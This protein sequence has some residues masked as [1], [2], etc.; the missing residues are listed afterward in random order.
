MGMVS[1]IKDR[2]R[3]ADSAV[4]RKGR[5][6]TIDV[7]VDPPEFDAED[8]ILRLKNHKGSV[9]AVADDL[10]VDSMRLRRWVKAKPEIVH[11]LEE[12]IE[13][14]LDKSI[15]IMWDGLEDE[16]SFQNRFYAAK[17]FL[18][19]DRARARGFGRDQRMTV[20]VTAPTGVGVMTIRWVDPAAEPKMKTIEH[21]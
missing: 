9:S 8:I 18:S 6:L 12:V 20:G 14:A 1:K 13:R 7:V 10:G 2:D 21:E 11:V 19:N 4:K 17:V 5:N 3:R 16:A 15:D